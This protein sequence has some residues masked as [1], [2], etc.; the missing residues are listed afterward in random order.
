MQENLQSEMH[1]PGTRNPPISA[2]RSG[3]S[4]PLSRH[5]AYLDRRLRASVHVNTVLVDEEEVV[6]A[7]V[8]VVV[9]VTITTTTIMI[10]RVV[11]PV[12]YTS[13]R[14]RRRRI[15]RRRQHCRGRRHLSIVITSINVAV[16]GGHRRSARVSRVC[17]LK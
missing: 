15:R 1:S 3:A 11:V 12:V 17:I 5:R 13:S 6:V 8:V 4:S 7:G 16:E 14:R 10:V 9:V 2:A